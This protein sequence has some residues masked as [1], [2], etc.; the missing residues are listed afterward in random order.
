MGGYGLGIYAN[1][2][3]GHVGYGHSGFWGTVAL[4][5]P[6]DD[7]TVAVAVTEQSQYGAIFGIVSGLG[8]IF[9]GAPADEWLTVTSGG[10]PIHAVRADSGLGPLV[11][12]AIRNGERLATTFFAGAS[13][14]PYTIE[15]YPDRAGLIAHWRVVREFS[16][17]QS[18]CWLIASAWATELDLLS[19]RVWSRDACGHDGNDT[20]HIRNVLAHE[21]VHVI[22]GQL[23]QHATLS[24]MLSAQWLTEGLAVYI[25]GVL[26]TEYAGV[27]QARLAAG[28]APSTLAE[29]WNEPANYP[30]SGSIV[31]Y[32]DRRYG[33]TVLRDL[34][35]ARSTT[36]VLT[37][38][39]VGEAE[40]LTAW[41]ADP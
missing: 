34:L 12:D 30:L 41:R 16:W 11:A 9:F 4:H 31:R 8:K 36:E 40:L 22:H 1:N 32:I 17:P 7:L 35:S 3:S 24:T 39:G 2:Q 28:F 18:P 15:I 25:T 21:V 19:P 38:L 27:V 14:Q 29:V 37:R 23:G 6:K 20:T 10:L 33:R 13:M 26:E 5:F